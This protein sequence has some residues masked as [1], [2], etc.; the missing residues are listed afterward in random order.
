MKKIS[1]EQ[2]YKNKNQDFEFCRNINFRS[3]YLEGSVLFS[4]KFFYT[5]I[6]TYIS[7]SENKS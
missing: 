3:L 4:K 7:E 6:A 1:N 2:N 5:I